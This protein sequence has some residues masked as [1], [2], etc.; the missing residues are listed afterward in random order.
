LVC[1]AIAAAMLISVAPSSAVVWN[2]TVPAVEVRPAS[3][4][5]VFPS[6]AFADGRAKHFLYKHSPNE[7]IRFFIIKSDDGVIRAAFDACD[8]CYRSRKGY[9]QEGNFMVCLNCGLKFRSNK[10][11]EV[12]GGCNPAP[13]KRVVQGGNL[14]ISQRDLLSGLGFFK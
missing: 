11:N 13:L 5:I 12:K 7:W 9:R 6:S 3:G 14:V 2:F 4:V 1:A 10:I 8:V